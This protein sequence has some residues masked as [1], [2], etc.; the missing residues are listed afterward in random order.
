MT[1]GTVVRSMVL[2]GGYV[3]A[4]DDG[5]ISWRPR[6]GRRT[7]Y[8]LQ[9]P[10]SIL[11]GM[12]GPTGQ[13]ESIIIGDTKGNVIR[14]SLPK[15]ELLDAFETTSGLV[16]SICRVSDTSDRILVGS[17]SGHVWLLGRDVPDNRVL[18]FIH[19]QCITSIRS[20]DNEITLQSGWSKYTYNWQG[21]MTS[22]QCKMDL[23]KLKQ[24]ER[25]NR[26]AKLLQR[27]ENNSVFATMLDLPMVG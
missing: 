16:R 21:I 2:S 11:L 3:I 22:N 8:R 19:N 18:L 23:F 17:D 7:N 14:L 1:S 20:S 25:S 26:R 6:G 27:K 5:M 13:C 24:I 4:F 15:L 9:Y 12:K 10:A